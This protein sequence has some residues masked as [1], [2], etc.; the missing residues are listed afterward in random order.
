MIENIESLAD[1]SGLDGAGMNS[2]LARV[3]PV[4][5]IYVNA[6]SSTNPSTLLGF[7]TWSAFGAG[8]V[9][10]GFNGADADF[11]TAGKTGGSKTHTLTINEMPT[12][13]HTIIRPPWSNAERTGSNDV[14]APSAGP[15]SFVTK[16]T[17]GVGGI[18]NAGGGA[19]HPNVQPYIVVY[20]W[21][22]TA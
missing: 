14:W 4:G 11:N 1:G 2:I 19:A 18:Q 8:R 22:R 16:T 15:Y 12:H 7:G 9:P 10:V 17:T 5:S 20:M 6:T 3:Y 21:K 13:N